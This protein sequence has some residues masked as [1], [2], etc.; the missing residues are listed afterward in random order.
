MDSLGLSPY[1]P[2]MEAA[3]LEVCWVSWSGNESVISPS[4]AKH[5]PI[6][7]AHNNFEWPLCL[8]RHL[9]VLTAHK[10]MISSAN[11]LQSMFI[12]HNP[13]SMDTLGPQTTSKLPSLQEENNE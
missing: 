7:S 5:I 2:N 4:H 3:T 9:Q 8:V 13:S 10:L 1:L 11:F 12:Q 6:F